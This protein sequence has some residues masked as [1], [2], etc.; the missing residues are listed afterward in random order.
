MRGRRR[1]GLRRVLSLNEERELWE[2]EEGMSSTKR[3]DEGV[4]ELD[5]RIVL[6][7]KSFIM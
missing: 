4:K 1:G 7:C 5:T 3:K 2:D 6:G